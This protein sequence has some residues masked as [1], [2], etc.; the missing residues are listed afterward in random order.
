MITTLA[1]ASLL[2]LTPLPSSATCIDPA[3]RG[4]D[5]TLRALYEGG[6]SYTDFLGAA[7]RRVEL[8]HGNGEKAQGIDPT[9][10]QR[11][12][13][14]GGSWRFLAVAVDS[15][16]DSVSTI[17]YLAQLV[18]MVDGLD[19]RIID[20]TVGRAIMESH[21]TPDGRAAT[22]TV[23]LLNQDFEEAGCFIERPPS[24]QTWILENNGTLSGSE[25]VDQKM[26]WYADDAG[27]ETLETFVAMLEAAGTGSTLC[28]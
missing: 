18:S 5:D 28:S 9:L 1:I 27:Q 3:E 17:P 25:I 4:V 19:M 15:C 10:V 21:R 24:L 6:R 20:S 13:A 26:Q 11:A 2:A 14:V 7:T 23:L 8:W 22:P 16:S 12:K